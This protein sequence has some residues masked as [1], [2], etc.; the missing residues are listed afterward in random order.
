MR[1][2]R[3]SGAGG[4]VAWL[5]LLGALPAGCGKQEEP[6]PRPGP[7][8]EQK[9]GAEQKRDD[10]AGKGADAL[11]AARERSKANLKQIALAFLNHHDVYKYFPVGL[12]DP[13]SGQVGLS[14]RVQILPF[15]D[16]KAAEEL[17]KQFR[18]D[19]PWDS[20]HNKKLLEKMPRVYA[21]VRGQ[22]SP[23]HTFYQGFADHFLKAGGKEFGPKEFIFP[24]SLGAL[25]PDPRT[26]YPQGKGRRGGFPVPGPRIFS[27]A[28]GTANT[29]LVVEAG[30]AV[31]WSKPQDIP[32]RFDLEGAMKGGKHPWETATWPKLGGMFDGDFH[33]VMVDGTVYYIKKDA[34]G[35]KL[36]PFI[37][38][39]DG[40]MPDYRGIGLE[41][42][43]WMREPPPKGPPKDGGK[44]GK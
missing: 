28:D 30:A 35:E 38:P 5:C 9:P 19:E 14:W 25:F 1:H 24:I 43:A 32:F 15:L 39:R 12:I 3:A 33:A 40:V 4:V 44:T 10:K 6:A 11:A 31:P 22:A 41:E 8:V 34:P 26:S 18:L 27:I 29:F 17:Y 42:P 2:A 7:G 21:P 23:G 37:T 36:R 13:K 20:D 16:D